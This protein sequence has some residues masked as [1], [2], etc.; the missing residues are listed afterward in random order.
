MASREEWPII[1]TTGGSVDRSQGN[2]D[3]RQLNGPMHVRV[4]RGVGGAALG[5]GI[6]FIGA[7]ILTIP[8]ASNQTGT[9]NTNGALGLLY[10]IAV[11]VPL[12]VLFAW[13]GATSRRLEVTERALVLRTYFRT[14]R[15]QWEDIADVTAEKSGD[16]TVPVVYRRDRD[17][18]KNR[19]QLR[20]DGSSDV[21]G[22][23]TRL[24]IAAGK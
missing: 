8:M 17:R 7:T 11:T 19:V 13:R 20:R 9:P 24:R 23:V 4:R 18:P 22:I 6:A 1:K 5:L 14:R 15:I 21:S 12:M 16:T 3:I 10:P 2:A